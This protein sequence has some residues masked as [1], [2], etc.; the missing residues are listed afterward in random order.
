METAYLNPPQGKGRVPPL[1][2][3]PDRAMPRHKVIFDTDPGVDD[4]MALLYI[5][6]NPDFE[7]L[8]ITTVLG[9][10]DIETTTRNALYLTQRFAIAAPVAKGAAEPLKIKRT[11]SPSHVHGENGMG[12]A[13]VPA[14]FDIAPDP[15]PAWRFIVDT[16]KAHPHQ[17][18]VIAVGRMTNLALALRHEPG[19]AKLV[20]AVS[21]MGGAFGINGHSGNVTPVAE[22]NIIGD[23]DAAGE[24]L[25]A[26]WPVTVIGLDVTL[27]TVMTT[28]YLR[29]LRDAGGDA[30][31]FMWEIS[32]HYEKYYRER[33]GLDGIACHDS[34]AVAY[35]IEPGWFTTRRGPV[36]VATEGV[37]IGQTIQ[38]HQ[39][40]AFPGS[41][42]EGHPAQSVAIA[43][44]SQAFLDHFFEIFR[45][46]NQV[47]AQ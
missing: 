45:H 4:A 42:W 13:P 30:G 17:V 39:K 9:N 38:H 11:R 36:R 18:T 44:N 19:I 3:E 12:N 21:I 8:G 24:V 10:A 7:L 43:V 26:P 33:A 37:A 35:V 31:A 6:Y 28:D 22:A 46:A 1:E 5:H 40:R 2:I 32:R 15:R 47:K 41:A 20:K 34:L 27:E 16:V 23:P 29:R 25:T 14:T